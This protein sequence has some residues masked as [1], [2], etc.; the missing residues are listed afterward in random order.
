MKK[1]I[2]ASLLLWGCSP[3]DEL[4]H[5]TESDEDVV[6]CPFDETNDAAT[7]LDIA[8]DEEGSGYLCPVGD[9]DWFKFTLDDGFDLAWN[10]ADSSV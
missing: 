10:I 2:L 3:A 7:A 6:P 9:Q 8:L 4:F 5:E 1:L